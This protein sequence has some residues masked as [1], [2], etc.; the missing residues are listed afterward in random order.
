MAPR[1]SLNKKRLTKKQ[2]Q[3][4]VQSEGKLHEEYT[5]FFKETYVT[6][7]VSQ[8]LIYELPFDR[9][10]LVFD[11]N[12]LSIP[13]KGDIYTKDYFLRLIKWTKRV[14]DDYANNRASSVDH[15]R[16]YSK[17]GSKLIDNMDRLVSELADELHIDIKLLDKSYKSLDIVSGE[18]ENYGIDEICLKLYDN[19]V[20]YVGETIRLKVKGE[21]KVNDT[22]L[23]GDYPYIDIGLKNVHYMP[24]NIVWDN[25]HG[26]DTVDLRKAVGNEAREKGFKANFEREFGHVIQKLTR[27]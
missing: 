11:P 21:W 27:S 19:V 1:K 13:G 4:I 26:L 18:I 15:W 7:F 9:F 6:G 2:V 8:D 20:A 17:Y 24:I 5:E 12:G 23:G 14:R 3:E 16:F 22:S 25:L 10:L